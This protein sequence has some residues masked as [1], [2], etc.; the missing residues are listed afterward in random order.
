MIAVTITVGFA[1]WAWAR[2]AAVSSESNYGSAVASNS[3][4]LK[5]NFV[6]VNA[7]F[8]STAT[9]NVTIWIYDNGNTAVYIKQIFISNVTSV[10]SLQWLYTTSSLSTGGPT[11]CTSCLQV[12][13]GYVAHITISAN[14]A[15]KSGV[16]YQIEAL[17]QYGNTYSYE[18][19]R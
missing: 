15:F 8:S 10:S 14:K 17:G 11:G 2:S 6:I 5:E 12:P 13:V 1:A 19:T 4:Y 3:S 9:Q 16:T 18:Q 7:N